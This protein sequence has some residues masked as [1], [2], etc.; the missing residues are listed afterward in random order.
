MKCPIGGGDGCSVTLPTPTQGG[1][2]HPPLRETLQTVAEGVVP[3]G[4]FKEP[5]TDGAMSVSGRHCTSHW[6][7]KGYHTGVMMDCL[8][9]NSKRYHQHMGYRTARD[10]VEGGGGTDGHPSMCKPPVERCIARIQ[11]QKK[12]REGYNG[13]EA[14]LKARQHRQR[15]PLTGIPGP[16]KGLLHCGQRT[17]PHN[18]RRVLSGPLPVLTLGDLLGQ[19]ASGTKTEWLPR[20]GLTRHKGY[21]AGRPR[22]SDAFQCGSV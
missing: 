5:L 9:P 4:E 3:L 10:S 11:V 19:P 15:P 22:I 7:H 1:Q 20:T 12:N 6:A 14:L 13:V 17:P 8:G 2:I 16:N 18:N 21:N